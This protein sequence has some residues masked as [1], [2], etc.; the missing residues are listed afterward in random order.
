M[1]F[2]QVDVFG[3]APLA[4]NPLA[5]V[6]DAADVPEAAMRAFARWT[7]LSETAFVL[8]PTAPGADYRVRIFTPASE[9]P[10]AGH[11]TLGSAHA[12][13]ERT[14]STA[15]RLVQECA[16]GLVELRRTDEGW[17]FAAPPFLR[18]GP[19]DDEEIA[20]VAE[21]LGIGPWD[22]VAA[23]WVD[24]G[25]GW[26]AVL[27]R[28]ADAV[29]EIQ[30]DLERM[31]IPTGVVGPHGAGGRADYEV[32]AFVPGLGVP[33]DPVTGSLNAGIALWF[34]G[35]GRATGG[36]TVRQGTRVGADGRVVVTQEDDRVWIAGATRTVLDGTASF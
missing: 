36:Y 22:V 14:G 30:P 16:A 4:G 8:P 15:D 10:F 17:A 19:A 3:A 2:R 1:P 33:E 31:R 25:P 26:L 32:R 24:N 11:P 6:L 13:A 28:D 29:L 18:S 34:L 20:R 9:L 23:E 21:G 5:V 12:W 35:S 7:N 27:L